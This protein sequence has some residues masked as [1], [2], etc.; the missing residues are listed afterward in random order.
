[1]DMLANVR[2]KFHS[3]SNQKETG[4][5]YT[6]LFQSYI[7]QLVQGYPNKGAFFVWKAIQ[8]H[9]P[10][11]MALQLHGMNIDSTLYGTCIG[12]VECADLIL[13]RCSYARLIMNKIFEWCGLNKE[14]FNDVGE[15]LQFA[16]SMGSMP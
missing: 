15:L 8:G 11:A 3:G 13:M 6:T 9:I 2:R 16:P 5:S 4:H 1:M 12:E 14:E 7:D 10:S